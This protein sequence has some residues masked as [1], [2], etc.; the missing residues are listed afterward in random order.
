[1]FP[2]SR[3]ADAPKPS[4]YPEHCEH[5]N[6]IS[7]D[8]GLSQ[9]QNQTK[10]FFQVEARPRVTVGE[11]WRSSLLISLLV[12]QDIGFRWFLRGLLN[13]KGFSVIYTGSG[14]TALELSR[15]HCPIDLLVADTTVGLMSGRE[16][17]RRISAEQPQV[18][19]LFM[20]R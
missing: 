5:L 15:Q 14:E 7:P 1:L 13:A 4:A 12:E 17:Y 6:Q 10:L 19:V 2:R 11:A 3:E 16:L 8:G 9:R 18:R 20:S